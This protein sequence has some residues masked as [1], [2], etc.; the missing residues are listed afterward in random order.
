M[1]LDKLVKKREY[2][3]IDPAILY[4]MYTRNY[5]RRT[6]KRYRVWFWITVVAVVL[7][8]AAMVV[9][10]VLAGRVGA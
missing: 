3:H 7:Q 9:M 2:K 5:G 10:L 4:A 8:V 6:D 1:T